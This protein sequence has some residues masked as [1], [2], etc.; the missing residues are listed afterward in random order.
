VSGDKYEVRLSN[1]KP[2]EIIFLLHLGENTHLTP[3]SLV[4]Y[5][6][7]LTLVTCYLIHDSSAIPPNF[8]QA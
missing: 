8:Y 1:Y 6:Y 4:L 3:R 7:Y 5:Y 2:T